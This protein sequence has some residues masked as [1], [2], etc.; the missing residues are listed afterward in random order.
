MKRKMIEVKIS[1]WDRFMIISRN[2]YS[3][4]KVKYTEAFVFDTQGASP[5]KE[6]GKKDISWH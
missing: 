6:D 1:F 2:S 3:G 4:E 5:A